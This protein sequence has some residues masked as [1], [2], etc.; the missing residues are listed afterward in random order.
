MPSVGH[1][2]DR[3]D[4]VPGLLE[5]PVAG[6]R[7]KQCNARKEIEIL[8]SQNAVYENLKGFTPPAGPGSR[9]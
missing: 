8:I 2:G 6:R 5:P 1:L 3:A 9:L 4:P 7:Q